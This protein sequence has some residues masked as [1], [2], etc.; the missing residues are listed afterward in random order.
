MKKTLKLVAALL[1][2]II[3][4]QSFTAV[5]FAAEES[6]FTTESPYSRTVD[7]VAQGSEGSAQLPEAKDSNAQ[8]I[9]EIPEKRTESTKTFLMSDGSFMLAA[10]NEPVHYK[11]DEGVWQDIDNTLSLESD[12]ITDDLQPAQSAVDSQPTESTVNSKP[13]ESAVDSQPTESTVDSKPAESTVDSQLT[14]ST[15]DSKPAESVVA[16]Q[17]AGSVADSEPAESS[18]VTQPAKNAVDT[19]QIVSALDTQQMVNKA[20]YKNKVCKKN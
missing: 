3:I 15:V 5:A 18:V 12:T 17:P 9:T 1:S 10:Y 8:I 11:D 13:A 20:A 16:S 19:Q 14:G 6:K 7:P 4:T 2:V